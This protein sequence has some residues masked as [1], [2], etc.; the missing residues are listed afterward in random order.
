MK[1]ILFFIFFCSVGYSA[2]RIVTPSISVVEEFVL[3]KY[4]EFGAGNVLVVFDFDNT[5]MA[6]NNDLGSDQWYV[7]QSDVIKNGDKKQAMAGDRAELFELHYKLFALGNMHPVEKETANLV[8]KIQELKIR[9]LI[10]TSRG[11]EF[12][13]DT[14]MELKRGGMDFSITAPGPEGGYAF[15]FL[16]EG[17]ENAR[18]VSYQNGIFMGSGQNKGIL[19][20]ALIK[21]TGGTFKSIIVVDDTLKNIENIEAVYK[22]DNSFALFFYTHEEARVKKFEKDKSRAWR[23][24]KTLK[25]VLKLYEKTNSEFTK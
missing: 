20:Q 11:S 3:K 8:K 18:P 12:R 6:M 7:W 13:T 21:K 23:E 5:L 17:L 24:W 9:T 4:A 1:Y 22:D 10:L 15:Q 14:E 16:P 2:E 25:P 19:L